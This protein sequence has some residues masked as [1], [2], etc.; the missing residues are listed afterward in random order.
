MD[1]FKYLKYRSKY[2]NLNKELFGGGIKELKI[3][4]PNHTE[5]IDKIY[6][7]TDYLLEDSDYISM[8]QL[9]IDI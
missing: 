8:I 6:D 9:Y 7:P 2:L 5:L 4:Y 3:K 1:K